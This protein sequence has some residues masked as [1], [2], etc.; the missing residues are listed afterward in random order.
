M[1]NAGGLGA[2]WRN[3]PCSG[4]DIEDIKGPIFGTEGLR[5][6]SD[7]TVAE[8]LVQSGLLGFV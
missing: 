5:D 1:G 6:I 4:E 7:I 3:G 8:E 2:P